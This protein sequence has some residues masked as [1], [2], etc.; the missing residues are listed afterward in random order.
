[1]VCFSDHAGVERLLKDFRSPHLLISFVSLTPLIE[2]S[3]LIESQT[4]LISLYPRSGVFWDFF[5][6]DVPTSPR[7]SADVVNSASIYQPHDSKL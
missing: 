2:S 1:M 4:R 5:G 3:L 6:R 7:G